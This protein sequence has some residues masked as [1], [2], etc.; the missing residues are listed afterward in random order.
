MSLRSYVYPQKIEVVSS[1]INNKIEVVQ[2][3]GKYSLHVQKLSQSGRLVQTLWKK[4]VQKAH[5]GKKDVSKILVLGMGGGSVIEVLTKQYP[6][7]KIKAIEIDRTMITLGRKYFH[8]NSYKNVSIE[9][10]DA[11]EWVK[12]KKKE[13]Y[14]LIIVDLF[15]GNKVPKELETIK[16]L[17][18][19]KKCLSVKGTIIINRIQKKTS[20]QFEKTLT[21]V[22]NSVKIQKV[23]IN[24]LYHCA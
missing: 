16:F 11:I 13:K 4:G 23:L 22:F 8:L 24:Y 20:I 19:S 1:Q 15:I 7:A 14:E 9:I 5:E 2:Y 17:V 10:A 18:N 12:N 3:C 21:S 6:K